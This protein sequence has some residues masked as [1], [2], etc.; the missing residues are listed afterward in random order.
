MGRMLRRTCVR[1]LLAQRLVV[2]PQIL[3]ANICGHVEDVV[4]RKLGNGVPWWHGILLDCSCEACGIEAAHYSGYGCA[5]LFVGY[6]SAR[7]AS[8]RARLQGR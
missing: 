6:R 5:E 1:N 4:C 3:V 2:S 8:N 7:I